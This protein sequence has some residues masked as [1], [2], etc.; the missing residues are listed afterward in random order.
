[1]RWA[2]TV[3]SHCAG[4]IG[5]LCVYSGE[6]VSDEKQWKGLLRTASMFDNNTWI[7]IDCFWT[8]TII[9]CW[10]CRTDTIISRSEKT[11]NWEQNVTL[12]WEGSVA[13]RFTRD[14]TSRS[15][16][17][18]WL[19]SVPQLVAYAA[20][21]LTPFL[22][23][24]DGR[25]ISPL[26]SYRTSRPGSVQTHIDTGWSKSLCAWWLQYRKLQVTV[27]VSPATL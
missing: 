8:S 11:R 16:H 17:R 10:H 25:M 9:S 6:P 13:F 18:I 3:N 5:C 26:R 21:Q 7:T 4:E 1:M 27:K 19:D 23:E 20:G 14:V 24:E 22:W 15:E 12:S 2:P